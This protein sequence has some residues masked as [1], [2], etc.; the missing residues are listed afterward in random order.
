M[1]ETVELIVKA[2]VDDKTA[3][4]VRE[5]DRSGL[6]LIE[7]RV[8]PGDMGKVI[9]KQGR[10]VKALRSLVGAVGAKQK[11]RLSLEIVETVDER[12]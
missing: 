12:A 6:S 11:R 2:L 3:V 9:G 8:A 10:T 5:I 1:R 7:V 4:D